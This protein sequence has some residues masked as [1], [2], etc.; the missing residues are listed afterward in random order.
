M[1][2]GGIAPRRVDPR[3]EAVDVDHQDH[4]DPPGYI[5]EGQAPHLGAF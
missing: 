2:G 5:D 1:V 4:R 3:I